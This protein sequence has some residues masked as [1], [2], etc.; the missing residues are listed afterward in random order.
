MER[1]DWSLL[2]E[3]FALDIDL[4]FFSEDMDYISRERKN[5]FIRTLVKRASVI[6]IAFSPYFVT[7]DRAKRALFEILESE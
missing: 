4:D 2:D 7:F 3:D 6:L 1:F 5:E